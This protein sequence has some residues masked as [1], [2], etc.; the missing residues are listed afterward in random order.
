MVRKAVEP[1][2]EARQD[3][4]ILADLAKRILAAGTIKI[5]D[6]P[7]ASWEYQDTAQIMMEIAALTPSYAGVSHERIQRGDCLQWPV[8]GDQHPGTPILH[9]D[10][11]ARGKGRFA[12]IEHIPPAEMPDADYPCF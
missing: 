2:G 3:W 9:V 12:P 7:Y 6:A 5:S 11:F 10:Q 1:P 4:R 8:K